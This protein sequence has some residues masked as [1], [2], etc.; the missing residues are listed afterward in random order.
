VED[1]LSALKDEVRKAPAQVE[2]RARLFALHCVLGRWDKAQADLGVIRQLDPSWTIPAQLYQSLMV[3]EVLRRDVF[4][5]QARP[6]IMGEPEP[7]V[8]WNVQA[9]ASE[10]EG[11]IGEAAD[12]RKQAWEAAPEFKCVVDGHSCQWLSDAD[13]RLGPVLEVM[14]PEFLVEVVW[15]PA[16]LFVRNGAELAAHLP[17]RY[18]G[19]ESAT[20]GNLC[21]GR[22]SDWIPGGD[23]TKR[24]I[25]QKMFE[26][27]AEQF[28]LLSCRVVDFE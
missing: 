5:G 2:L 24:P 22:S 25:G 26:S 3:A 8:G 20:D 16:K 12:L 15:V 9:L 4:A 21:L 17:A 19:T 27:E 6:L 18:P 14:A 10:A 11:R 7:W 1:A 28:G 13:R 23:G